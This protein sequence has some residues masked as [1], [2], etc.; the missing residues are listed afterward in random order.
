MRANRWLAPLTVVLFASAP[1]VALALYVGQSSPLPGFS[2]DDGTEL[3]IPEPDVFAVELFD[4]GVPSTTVLS[5]FGFYFA[6]DPS[7]VIPIFS[8]A[9][10]DLGGGDQ[11]AVVDFVAGTV[12]D[13]DESIAA[14]T[15]VFEASF[16]PVAG[17]LGFFYVLQST[18][19][20][21]AFEVALFTQ[22][23]LNG[24]VDYFGTFRSMSAPDEYL[25]GADGAGVD[26]ML[27]FIGGISPIPEPV[28]GVLFAAGGLVVALTLR[29]T[30][31]RPQRSEGAVRRSTL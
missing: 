21:N 28:S 18:D 8:M 26:L 14:G 9:D 23:A 29:K 3:W 25:I 17:P 5:A 7:V 4:V 31:R 22:S 20:N 19:P 27:N 11:L 15:E 6:D 30:A 12:L 24:G 13:V 2:A 10:Q 1:Q 16:T